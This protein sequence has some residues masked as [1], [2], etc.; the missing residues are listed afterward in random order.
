MRVLAAVEHPY[1]FN[2]CSGNAVKQGMALNRKASGVRQ[3]FGAFHPHEW[4]FCEH[5]KLI[6]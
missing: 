4:L 1:N 2:V 5:P 3:E 6:F